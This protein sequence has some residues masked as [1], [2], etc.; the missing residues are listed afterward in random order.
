M[1]HPF[2]NLSNI[3]A[4]D[5]LCATPAHNLDADVGLNWPQRL[6]HRG[7]GVLGAA[8]V[9]AA[10]APVVGPLETVSDE[11]LRWLA[12]G[13]FA[14][15]IAT[16]SHNAKPFIAADAGQRSRQAGDSAAALGFWDF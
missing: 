12:D 5:N 13:T 16:M 3:D 1:S 7:W 6:T 10:V 8:S 9:C 15:A 4:S 2:A 14:I 11:S